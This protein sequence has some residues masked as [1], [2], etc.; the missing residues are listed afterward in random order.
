MRA[1]R[2]KLL[3]AANDDRDEHSDE[4]ALLAHDGTD[5]TANDGSSSSVS[6]TARSRRSARIVDGDVFQLRFR[7]VSGRVIVAVVVG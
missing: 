6:R 3:L 1:Q 7:R 5:A 4:Q 2:N